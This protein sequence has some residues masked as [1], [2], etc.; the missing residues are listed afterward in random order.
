MLLFFYIKCSLYNVSYEIFKEVYKKSGLWLREGI[1]NR[2]M[3]RDGIDRNFK[4][5]V[6]SML[7]D[8]VEKVNNM[9]KEV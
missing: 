6:I 7:E 9:E 2:N 3:F 1:V 8:M 5:I 4:I